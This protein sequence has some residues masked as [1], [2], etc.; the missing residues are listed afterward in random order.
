MDEAQL[1]VVWGDFGVVVEE[2]LDE[3]PFEDE[4]PE[5]DEDDDEESP[6]ELEDPLEDESP[7]AAG[8]A[9]VSDVVCFPRLS[10]R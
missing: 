10:L 5:V 3:E 6:E 4:S 9:A 7:D 8:A 2:P 1:A